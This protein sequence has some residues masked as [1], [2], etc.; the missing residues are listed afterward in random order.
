M[1]KIDKNIYIGTKYGHLEIIGLKKKNERKGLYAECLCDCGNTKDILLDSLLYKGI[2]NCGCISNKKK[3][4]K[5]D[6]SGKRYGKLVAIKPTGEIT[7]GG[8][9]WKCQCDCGNTKGVEAGY[10][11]SGRIVDCGCGSLKRHQSEERMVDITGKRF[12]SLTAL[13]RAESKRMYGA[14]KTRWLC[15]CD[16]GSEIIAITGALTSGQKKSCGCMTSKLI[17][18]A[19][20]KH[21]KCYSKIYKVWGAIKFRCENPNCKEYKNYGGRGITVCPEWK[22]NF[23]SFYDWAM[24]NGYKDGLEIDRINNEGNYEPNNCEWT[25]RKE[26]QRNKRT[27]LIVEYNGEKKTLVEWSEEIGI[28]YNTLFYRIKSKNWTVEEAFT[29]PIGARKDL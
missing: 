18:K 28:N 24:E 6:I 20:E 3:S 5:I 16:C 23:Q 25:T 12:G 8:I 27:N 22:E 10:L 2:D 29:T 9:V 26:Q 11:N 15:R 1:R 14:T 13:K 19:H 7:S 17:I 21:G 4:H